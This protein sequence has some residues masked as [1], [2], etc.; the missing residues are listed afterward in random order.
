MSLTKILF[1]LA[2][3]FLTMSFVNCAKMPETGAGEASVQ[4]MESIE[5]ISKIRIFTAEDGARAWDHDVNF[6][7]N[8]NSSA[9]VQARDPNSRYCVRNG[10]LT[11]T[12]KQNLMDLVKKLKV[13]R[14]PNGDAA[15]S[16]VSR[17]EI[18]HKNGEVKNYY[19][20]EGASAIKGSPYIAQGGDALRTFITELERDLNINCVM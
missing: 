4:S 12:E 17:L 7:V 14:N 2:W 15:D 13:G 6:D 1:M 19:L 8:E 20:P 5:G 18:T 11:D 9:A 16:H 3:F 10:D